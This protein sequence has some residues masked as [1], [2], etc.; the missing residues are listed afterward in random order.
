MKY[1]KDK[2]NNV[3]AYESDG[4]Q[5]YFIGD[6]TAMTDEE[7]YAH[8]NPQPV[9]VVH[10]SITMR[11]C[12]LQLFADGCLSDIQAAIATMGAAV[13]IEWEYGT[14]VERNS[15]VVVALQA[16]VGWDEPRVD[17]FFASAGG[18]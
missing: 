13:Q 16:L 5:D 7:I 15:P 1:Y 9:A 2:E 17:T 14:S 3:F 12:R 4:T 18:L 8:I 11:Q 6:K 10:S